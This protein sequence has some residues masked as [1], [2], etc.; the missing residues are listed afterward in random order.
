MRSTGNRSTAPIRIGPPPGGRG[1]PVSPQGRLD[2]V[3]TGERKNLPDG[4]EVTL[5]EGH[6]YFSDVKDA[7][8]F[9]TEHGARPRA[10]PA[11]APAKAA[12]AMT[13]KMML[14]AKLDERYILG[15]IS[16]EKYEELKRKLTG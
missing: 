9:L 13:D 1:R 11:K 14:L 7:S 6:W 5:I 10:E 2:Q 15:E 4:R 16:E 8:T 12:V 3:A